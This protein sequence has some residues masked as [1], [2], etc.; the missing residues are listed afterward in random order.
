[1]ALVSHE[2]YR[3]VGL[4]AEGSRQHGGSTAVG[5]LAL[6]GGGLLAEGSRQ[7]GGS[8]AVGY[9]ALPGGGVLAVGLLALGCLH[10]VASAG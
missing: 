6:P 5:C 9:L 3:A 7:H 8:T 1:M 10:W 4:L 2:A